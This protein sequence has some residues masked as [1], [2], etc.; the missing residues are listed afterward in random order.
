M[1]AKV[2]IEYGAKAVD[3]EFTY[4]V[5]DNLKDKIKIGHRVLVPFNNK[6]IEG[7]VLDISNKYEDSY[8]LK[9]I[10]SLCDEMPILNKE[11]L[12]LGNEIQKNI[13]CS[14]IAIYQAMLPKAL[15]ASKNTNIGIKQNRYIV[16]NVS[17][18]E[19]NRYI[20]NCKFEGQIKIL[21]KLIVEDK[22]LVNNLSSSVNT[23][24]KNG[25][26]KF[27][28][29]EVNRYQ[30]HTSGKYHKVKLNDM[31]E[32]VVACVDIDKHDT[33]LLYGVTGSGKTEVYME[34]ID[35]VISKGK[36]AIMLVPEISLTP[37]IVDRFVTRFGEDVA[38]LH[39]GLSDYEKYDEYRKIMNGKV[40]IVVGAR[41]AIFAP[42]NNLGIIVIDEEHSQTYKQD[43]NPRY[44]ARDVA[45][46]RGKYHNAPV[47]LG[48]A[49][50]S[51]ESFAR[52][53]KGVY[54]LLTLT[55][56]AGGGTLPNVKIIDMKN[57][58]KKG[59]FILS[60]ELIQKIKE[61]IDNNEQIILLLNRRGYSSMLTCRDCGNVLKCPNCDISLTYHKTSNTNRCHYCNYSIKNIA[62]CP[63][64][65]SG[66]IK[67]YGLG[68]EKLE[69]ELNK[70]FK[71]RV[72][73]MDMDTTSRKGMHEKII[74]DFGNHKYDILLGTQMIAKGLDFP[75]VTLV[76]VINADSSLNIPDFRSAE[77]TFQLLSQVSGR[78]GRSDLAGE[79]IIQSYNPEHYSINLAKDHN[80]LKFYEAEMKIRKTLSYPPY[81]YITLVN[82]TSRDYE[83]G[84]SEANKIGDYLRKNVSVDTKILG[85][86]M[87][88]VF[89]I[90]NVYHYQCI[91]K[92][93]KDD[94]LKNV[95][96]KLDE[97]Y[98]TNNKVDISI[99]VNPIRV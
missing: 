53:N 31:Q 10:K 36:T 5:P 40:K 97:I 62:K 86:S 77:N 44:H 71:A 91:I 57:E 70:M 58:V 15:K 45:I 11:M 68:T 38:I 80:Y 96:L 82:I 56:R 39:S 43:N 60:S 32:K 6:D 28:Y 78:A 99:D 2:I 74:E 13:L 64:C 8:E 81:F 73:R 67:D 65:G 16:L 83:L 35:K 90:N 52:A 55:K 54:K 49:T 94:K 75:L 87:A 24:V 84:F 51:L 9:E 18:V 19:A 92:Y 42:L 76:G 17:D 27:V 20:E 46:L 95:L 37:Q 25:I 66:N 14:K 50:P 59:N 21:E 48:S 41:S 29:E 85:P 88:S 1:Y 4:I 22:M 23:L 98:K 89:K 33:Y 93:K 3:R 12:Y 47:I 69:E 61:K 26:V 7:F 72:V 63:V 30:S 79:V 34:L